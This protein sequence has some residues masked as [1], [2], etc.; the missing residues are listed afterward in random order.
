MT[1]LGALSMQAK[2]IANGK[3]PI[4]LNPTERHGMLGWGKAVIQ[5]GGF[6]AFGD[7][8]AVDQTKYGNTWASFLA[9]PQFAAAESVLGDF[10]MEEHS[11][12]SE[13]ARDAFPRRRGLYRRPLPAGLVAVVRRLAF[14][15]E[16]LDQ[17]ARMIDPRAPERFQRMEE[18]ARKDWG[19]SYWWKP[20]RTESSRPP[21]LE[22][23]LGH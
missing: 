13:G 16:M 23:V 2:E 18:S 12:G 22:A 14:Q 7:M 4:S 5:G 8:L 9:G 17:M 20:G 11:G 15:R 21:T 10:V 19:Q 6:G 1:G 3:D